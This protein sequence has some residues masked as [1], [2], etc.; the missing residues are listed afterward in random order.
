M[1]DLKC[2]IFDNLTQDTGLWTKQTSNLA[3][4]ADEI[5]H[6]GYLLKSCKRRKKHTLRYFVL[7]RTKL[8]YTKKPEST[9]VYRSLDLR[10]TRVCYETCAYNGKPHYVIKFVNNAKFSNLIVDDER[11]F[12][13]WRRCLVNVC[14]QTNFRERFVPVGEI[15]HGGFSSVYLALSR[16]NG[17][18]YAVKAYNKS[19][20]TEQPNIVLMLLS[21]I[22]ILRQLEH[23]NLPKLYEVHESA[24]AVYLVMEHVKGSDLLAWINER[25]RFTETEIAL[26]ANKLL[27]TLTYLSSKEVIHRDI[28]PG[29]IMLI[30]NGR[31]DISD[32]K[33]VDF[34]LAKLT[35]EHDLY[36]VCGTPGYI[37]PEVLRRNSSTATRVCPKADVF[38]AGMV[39]YQLVYGRL[40]FRSSHT[41]ELLSLNKQCKVS[42]DDEQASTNAF[43]SSLLGFMLE[44]KPEKRVDAST[45]LTHRYFR[46]YRNSA[47]NSILEQKIMRRTSRR[48]FIY[49]D[50][51]QRKL[52][53]VVDDKYTA[54]QKSIRTLPK[55]DGRISISTNQFNAN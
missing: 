6:Q 34:G 21:E 46:V 13:T 24:N 17:T 7:T 49:K 23:P 47:D 45:A 10:W 32:I 15:G 11:E 33:L 19:S 25:H 18:R 12:E 26:I 20:L 16:E 2:S 31:G 3:E 38:S 41:S 37:A 9:T 8:L 54:S 53:E 22:R 30:K 29:N 14:V 44:A 4:Y 43:I 55:N 5:L 36:Q 52:Y 51:R 50:S 48:A 1:S 42:L 40:P 35:H 28:K 27:Q 39:L